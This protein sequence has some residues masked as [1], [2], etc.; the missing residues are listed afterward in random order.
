MI[1]ELTM[2]MFIFAVQVLIGRHISGPVTR[3]FI[4][5]PGRYA[6]LQLQRRTLGHLSAVYCL[7]FDHSGRYII[8]VSVTRIL[9]ETT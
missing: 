5:P 8:T 3:R 7:L 4:L 6:D 2:L 9:K 1:L